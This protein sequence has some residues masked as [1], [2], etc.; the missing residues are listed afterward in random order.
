MLF[1]RQ[2]FHEQTIIDTSKLAEIEELTS[3]AHDYRCHI[4][5][6]M[7]IVFPQR[8]PKN[9]FEAAETAGNGVCSAAPHV[10]ED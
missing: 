5:W 4:R 1:D 9:C 10:R 2:S 7:F 8:H 6:S 3:S